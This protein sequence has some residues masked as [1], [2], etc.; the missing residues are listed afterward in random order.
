M[1]N[2]KNAIIKIKT[3][4]ILLMIKILIV[5]TLLSHGCGNMSLDTEDS[6]KVETPV[7]VT[8]I[9]DE[10][11]GKEKTPIEETQST[12]IDHHVRGNSIG[13]IVNRGL[14][15][16]Q[17]EWIYYTYDVEDKLS[18]LKSKVNGEEQ[19]VLY[20][21]VAGNINIIDDWI[22]FNSGGIFKIKTDGS[23]LKRLNDTGGE[24]INVVGGWIYYA[25]N[26]GIYKMITDGSNE[27]KLTDDSARD[28]NIV[29]GWA[30]YSNGNDNLSIYK[31]RTDGS[32]RTKLNDDI[33]RAI[34][35]V[36]D[37]IYYARY[38][39]EPGLYRIDIDGENKIQIYNE[40]VST[41]N[42]VDDWIY[43]CKTVLS[44]SMKDGGYLT[45]LG[46]LHKMRI[47]GSEVTKLDDRLSN[48]INVIDDWIYLQVQ[49]EKSMFLHRI[50]TDGSNKQKMSEL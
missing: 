28:M 31:I 6:E 8:Q 19:T 29:D 5:G 25:N 11:S 9:S 36:N 17:G 42:V 21:N 12:E 24:F 49:E 43:F 23:E 37:K 33:S 41:L 2:R 20:N 22:Y 15:A 27:E 39:D 50:K 40:T 46:Q 30:Y 7:N 4:K 13:N 34:N 32:D 3:V 45:H 47:D 10:D 16:S 48:S 18:L 38:V 1:F 14:V 35:V 26:Q 44:P